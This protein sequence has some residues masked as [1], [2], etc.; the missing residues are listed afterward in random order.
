M[1]SPLRSAFFF[2]HTPF[3]TFD[4]R[5]VAPPSLFTSP[6]DRSGIRTPPHLGISP[7]CFSIVRLQQLFYDNL[8]RAFNCDILPKGVP[9]LRLSQ[10]R[11]FSEF[12]PA[13]LRRSPSCDFVTTTAFSTCSYG[14]PSSFSHSLP[15]PLFLFPLSRFT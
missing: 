15:S 3:F 2:A 7:A 9:F 1:G 12:L 13:F 5:L 4:V 8:P 11:F 6:G 14:F 10:F